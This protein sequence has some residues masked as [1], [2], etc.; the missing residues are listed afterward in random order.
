MFGDTQRGGCSEFI[1]CS[2]LAV[3]TWT[4]A[5]KNFLILERNHKSKESQID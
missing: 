2:K 5:N 3:A 4:Y 1:M